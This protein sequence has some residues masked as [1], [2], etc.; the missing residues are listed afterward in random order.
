MP[1]TS[2]REGVKIGPSNRTQVTGII[3]RRLPFACEGDTYH[4]NCR[5]IE[6][7]Q[8]I[9]YEGQFLA[10]H[11]IHS[12]RNLRLGIRSPEAPSAEASIY[13]FKRYNMSEP[14]D[15]DAGMENDYDEE[16]DSDFDAGEA[17]GDVISSSSE[18][19]GSDDNASK[20]RPKKRRKTA[21]IA[22]SHEELGELDSGDEATIREHERMKRKQKKKKGQGEEDD[23]DV[24]EHGWRAR[25]RAMRERDKDEKKKNKLAS[26][27]GST[28]DVDRLWEEMNKPGGPDLPPPS[29]VDAS[30]AVDKE[31]KNIGTPSAPGDVPSESSMNHLRDANGAHKDATDWTE[32]MITIKRTYQF[33]GE[34]HSEEKIV[35]KSSAEAQLWLT[36]QSAK[37][38]PVKT[39]DSRQLRRPLRKISRFDPNLNNL[40]SIKKSWEKQLNADGVATGPKLNT[41]EK[42]KMDWAAHVDQEGLKDELDE[43]AKAKEGYL[44][45]M[46]FLGQVEQRREA[47]ARAARLKG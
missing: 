25:T 19:E 26:I 27:K 21:K 42:S 39:L 47:E 38:Q 14:Q 37:G 5:A 9:F 10:S 34:L 44:G 2:L 28:I 8:A 1:D 23:S 11:H 16:A 46:D 15:I 3:F 6:I 29:I 24:E 40:D 33:A 4:R 17:K 20:A 35:P 22:Q 13:C 7:G 36:Q 32:E 43:H 12:S 45:R 18:E 30:S 41:V 31:S